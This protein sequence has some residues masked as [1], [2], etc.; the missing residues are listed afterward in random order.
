[1]V[2]EA[3]RTATAIAAQA[4]V[5][6]GHRRPATS[7]AI[8]RRPHRKITII[9]RQ[10][11]TATTWTTAI[12][13]KTK[14]ET[15]T[16]LWITSSSSRRPAAADISSLKASLTRRVHR[17]LRSPAAAA[18]ASAATPSIRRPPSTAIERAIDPP[19]DR[20]CSRCPTTRPTNERRVAVPMA[21]R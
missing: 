21:T 4:V 13:S 16:T 7:K 10:P 3:A 11:A 17:T 15:P 1:M 5:A 6:T 19:P 20:W 14:T 9:S 18:A 12:D 2:A 8:K